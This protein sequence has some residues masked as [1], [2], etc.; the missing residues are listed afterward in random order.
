[1]TNA[2]IKNTAII[3]FAV[4][5]ISTTSAQAATSNSADINAPAPLVSLD[6][7]DNGSTSASTLGLEV[8][9]GYGHRRWQRGHRYYNNHHNRH[10]H[11]HR[12]YY[13]CK[14]KKRKVWSN[15]YHG[16]VWKKVKVCY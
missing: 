9:G 2:F 11:N 10:L 15:Y 12:V 7:I 6:I 1:M 16:W 13:G 4:A 5:A 14:W 3:A 8:A